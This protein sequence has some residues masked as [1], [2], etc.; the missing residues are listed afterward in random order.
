MQI[1]DGPNGFPTLSASQFRT[2]GTGGFLLE[3]N[4]EPKG[5]RGVSQQYVLKEKH[6]ES[7]ATRWCTADVPP[8]CS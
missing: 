3:F 8:P 5:C 6:P 4:E 2:Y 7:S 1:P